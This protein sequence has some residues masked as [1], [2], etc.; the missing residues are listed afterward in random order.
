M[1]F[2]Y[3]RTVELLST[4]EKNIRN[5]LVQRLQIGFNWANLVIWK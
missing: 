5:H 3:I 1:T 2:N 4:V